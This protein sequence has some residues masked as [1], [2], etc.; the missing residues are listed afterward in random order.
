M[1]SSGHYETHYGDDGDQFG[2]IS[3]FSGYGGWQDAVGVALGS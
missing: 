2:G 3:E 1:R